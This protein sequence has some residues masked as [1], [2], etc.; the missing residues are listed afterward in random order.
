MEVSGG[1]ERQQ[2]RAVPLSL[3]VLNDY[4]FRWKWPLFIYLRACVLDQ[5]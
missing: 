4:T 1:M 5:I 3:V 2:C